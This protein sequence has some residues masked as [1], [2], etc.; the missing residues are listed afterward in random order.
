MG[1][2]GCGKTTIGKL[3]A[4]KL[5]WRFNDADEFHPAA[6]VAKMSSGQ[7][8]NDADR[9]PW[10]QAIND[11]ITDCLAS[12]MGAVVTCSALKKT[13]REAIAVDPA[14]VKFVHLHGSREL[15]WERISSRVGHFMKPSMLDSQLAT[16]EIPEDAL[17]VDITTTPEVIV[18]S[19]RDSLSL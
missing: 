16:L 3:L 12:D 1:V 10:L 19:I 15:L 8:L 11:H 14:R 2:A 9:A 6:N 4:Q 18:A 7:P 13:Y 17:T 5:A